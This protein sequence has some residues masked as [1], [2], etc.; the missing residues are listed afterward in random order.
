MAGIGIAVFWLGYSITY[1]G[2]TQVRG[3]NWGFFDLVLPSRWPAK[4]DVTSDGESAAQAVST[5]KKTT[6]AT[7]SK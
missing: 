5:L 3:G 1:Y 7:G 6:A 4:A 2:V